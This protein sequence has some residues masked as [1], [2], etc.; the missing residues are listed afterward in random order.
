MYTVR[1]L[2]W[3]AVLA[4]WLLTGCSEAGGSGLIG[5]HTEGWSQITLPNVPRDAAFDAGVRAMQQWFR[6]EDSSPSSGVIHSAAV[7]YD[8]KGGTGRIRDTA[9][10]YRNRM[11][12]K[13]TLIVMSQGTGSVAK[14]SVSVQRLDTADHRVFQDNNR[15]QDYP[16][17]TPIDREAG[18]A[19]QTRPDRHARDRSLNRKSSASS[20]TARPALRRARL[21]RDSRF[22]PEGGHDRNSSLLSQDRRRA[23]SSASYPAHAAATILS[24]S[25]LLM[26]DAARRSGVAVGVGRSIGV[27]RLTGAACPIGGSSTLRIG[28]ARRASEAKGCLSCLLP[29]RGADIFT[30]HQQHEDQTDR[31]PE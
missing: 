19:N 29:A 9:I 6:L 21:R 26:G 2:W 24:R 5:E 3:A 7:E 14:C 31:A 13:A 1:N 25:S 4:P 23:T 10:G 28:S 12:H 20:A 18:L 30:I 17:Q 27:G 15:F 11:R 16:T 22:G 8:Q